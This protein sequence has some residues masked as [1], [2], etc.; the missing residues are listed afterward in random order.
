MPINFGPLKGH[1]R[2]T[3]GIYFKTAAGS[4]ILE[5][6]VQAVGEGSIACFTICVRLEVSMRQVNGKA[7]GTATFQFTFKV[8]FAEISYGVT[9]SYGYQGGG[10]GALLP[11][12]TR[13][14]ALEARPVESDPMDALAAALP[15]GALPHQRRTRVRVPRRDTEWQNYRK[16]YSYLAKDLA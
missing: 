4:T 6:F 8:G 9:A 5:G 3:A 12:L 14:A 16:Q 1:G 2:V 13:F 11:E 15:A 7:T 10:G